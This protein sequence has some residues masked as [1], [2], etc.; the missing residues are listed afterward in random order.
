MAGIFNEKSPNAT[1]AYVTNVSGSL[2]TEINSVSGSLNTKITNLSQDVSE[3]TILPTNIVYTDIPTTVTGTPS[4]G[5]ITFAVESP[6]FAISPVFNNN[7]IWL[8]RN[9]GGTAESV[10]WARASDNNTYLNWGSGD[11]LYL[12]D[13]SST[14]H[15]DFTSTGLDMGDNDLDTT[16]DIS[17]DN[18]TATGDVTA[19]AYYGDGSNLTGIGAGSAP[20]LACIDVYDN[21]GGQTFTTT[22]ITLN[23]DTVRKNV[24]GF[25]LASDEITAVSGTYMITMR[26]STGSTARSTAN[27]WIELDTGS[28]YNEVDGSRGVMYCRVTSV[29]ESTCTVPVILDLNDGDKL[30]VRM[31]SI[32]GGTTITTMVDASS[33]TI[34]TLG[35]PAGANG[36]DGI[37]GADGADG[38][39][40]PPGGGSTVNVYDA[41]STIAGNPFQALNFIG[42]EDITASVT[43]GTVDITHVHPVFGTWYGWALDESESSTTSTTYQQKL[44]YTTPST[45]P[46]GNYRIGWQF[47]WMRNT[48]SNDFEAQV[49]IDDTTTIMSQNEESKDVNSWH[50][51]GGFTVATLTNATHYIDVDYAGETTANT[52]YI[53]RARIEFYRVS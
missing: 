10:F 43:S 8:G 2:N 6:E 19:N 32:S 48:V 37:D 33:L 3:G 9:T 30:R 13:N 49:Q 47:E 51:V 5:S 35:G 41:G 15:Y 27:A 29:G 22:A 44:R 1:V 7:V 39:P 31:V 52:S 17:V 21:T 4:Q 28:G 11:H 45:V 53:R 38:A 18:I 24:G 42:M 16:G 36:Q 25:S 40:G 34:T 23:L 14:T 12:R 26:V 50:H 46:A 20:D